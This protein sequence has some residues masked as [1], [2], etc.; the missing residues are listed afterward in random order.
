M[1]NQVNEISTKVVDTPKPPEVELVGKMLNGEIEPRNE[2]ANYFFDKIKINI[3]DMKNGVATI[4]ELEK[5]LAEA[6]ETFN[7]LRAQTDAYSKDLLT[8]QEKDVP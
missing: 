4:K 5:A 1:E 8:W 2:M 6:R 3:V 7:N